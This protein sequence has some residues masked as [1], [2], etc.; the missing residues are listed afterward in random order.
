MNYEKRAKVTLKFFP[1]LA[2]RTQA[3]KQFR[4]LDNKYRVVR[5]PYTAF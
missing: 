2:R 4:S 3:D 1:S 5:I